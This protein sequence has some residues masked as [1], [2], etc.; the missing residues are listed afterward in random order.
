MEVD[1]AEL[2]KL[3]A[4]LVVFGFEGDGET[5]NEHA[6]RMI[7]RGEYYKERKRERETETETETENAVRESAANHKQKRVHLTRL[8]EYVFLT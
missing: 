6:K 3:A 8:G 4:T 2:R 1:D 7:K 5:P